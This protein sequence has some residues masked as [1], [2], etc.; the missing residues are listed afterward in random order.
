MKNIT[1]T[2]ALLILGLISVGQSFTPENSSI[3]SKATATVKPADCIGDWTSNDGHHLTLYG[4]NKAVWKDDGHIY[5]MTWHSENVSQSDNIKISLSGN[6]YCK[7]KSF[8]VGK[9]DNG[10][11][12]V[13]EKTNMHMH[14]GKELTA[15]LQ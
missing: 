3:F 11:E 12:I 14:P 2:S 7:P 8:S 9:T 6:N 13:E 15:T 5:Y 1:I 10:V 4:N